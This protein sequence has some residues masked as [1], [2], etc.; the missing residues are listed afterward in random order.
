MRTLFT[1]LVI[2]LVGCSLRSGREILLAADA[3]TPPPCGSGGSNCGGFDGGVVQP[4]DGGSYYPDGGYY[5]YDGGVYTGDDAGSFDPDG[6]IFTLDAANFPDA[7]VFP[8]GGHH[9]HS[10]PE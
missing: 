4:G 7:G 9:H 3:S 10:Q 5:D 1:F 8:D 2:A 6:G